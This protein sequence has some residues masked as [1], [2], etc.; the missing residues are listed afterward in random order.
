M[1]KLAIVIPYYKPNFFRDA[2]LAVKN[3]TNQNFRLYIGDDCSPH[4]P[5]EIIKEIFGDSYSDVVTYSRFDKNL[6]GA[7]LTAQWNRCIDMASQP[8]IWL[9]SDDDLMPEDAV[10]RFYFFCD[11]Y[12]EADLMRFN[13]NMIDD[14]ARAMPRRPDHPLHESAEAF[15]YRRLLGSCIS[16]ACE[17]IFTK[18][19]YTTK[20]GFIDFPMGWT[21]DDATW[22]NFGK[23]KGIYTIP[24]KPVLWRFGNFNISGDNAIYQDKIKA[25][26]LF[27]QFIRTHYNIDVKLQLNWLFFQLGLLSKTP[28]IIGYFFKKLFSSKLFNYS[29]VLFFIGNK[30]IKKLS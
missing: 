14:K 24:G 23:S 7:S 11:K 5:V 29:T 6:G 26:L 18:N 25:S 12:P 30:A 9:F 3:Q 22:L 16:S 27:V 19:V 1:L 10:D 21:A 28:Q 8:Y 17:Y 13:I 2:L 20:G 15:L 4:N